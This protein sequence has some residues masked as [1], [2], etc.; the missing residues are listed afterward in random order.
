MSAEQTV[1]QA[2][3]NN[4]IVIFSKSWCPYCQQAKSLF[5]YDLNRFQDKLYVKE[6][7]LFHWKLSPVLTA[8]LRIDLEAD[9]GE[10]IQ[11]YLK[12]KTTKR[13]VP[14]IFINGQF[15]GGKYQ[16]SVDLGPTT[17][18]NGVP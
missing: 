4:K 2:I 10:T 7:V 9:K 18:A 12:S 15:I 17:S 5:K 14:S 6:H 1:E 13:T 16:I 11:D 8:A 3:A